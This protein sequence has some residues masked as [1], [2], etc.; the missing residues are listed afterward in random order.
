MSD[1]RYVPKALKLS[2]FDGF[3]TRAMIAADREEDSTVRQQPSE[4]VERI[5]RRYTHQLIALDPSQLSRSQVYV[6]SVRTGKRIGD[7][8]EELPGQAVTVRIPFTGSKQLVQYAILT[9]SQIK[10]QV[11]DHAVELTIQSPGRLTPSTINSR[12]A[13]FIADVNSCVDKANTDAAQFNAQLRSALRSKIYD[14]KDLLDDTADLDAA[15]TIPLAAVTGQARVEVPV[16]RKSIRV[17]EPEAD[18]PSTEPHVSRLIYEDVL[19]TLSSFG[20]AMERLPDT[21]RS[22]GEEAIRD[23]AL[24]VLNANYEGAASGEVFNGA[25]KTDVLLKYQNKS[26]FIGEFKFWGG[27]KAFSSAINQLCSYLTWRDTKAALVLL[28][29]DVRATTAIEGAD[30][31]IRLHPQFRQARPNDRPMERRDYVLASNTDA[32]RLISIALLPVVI[33]D[34]RSKADQVTEDPAPSA[35]PLQGYPTAA[36]VRRAW[37][38][39]VTRVSQKSLRIGALYRDGQINAVEGDSL[40]LNFRSKLLSVM[41]IESS[42]HLTDALHEEFGVRFSINCQVVP[43]SS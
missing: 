32:D 33:P 5:A 26:A 27:P 9:Y 18:S 39:I 23:L 7:G 19:R 43:H 22:L 24:F 35:A 15:L 34:P 6:T 11:A 17:Q 20:R 1:S 21:A 28:V 25:G 31:A 40:V 2:I 14:R 4:V 13:E 10:P 41:A 29:K 16:Q 38:D 8:A 37:P 42:Q 36:D 30:Q 3:M 12:V